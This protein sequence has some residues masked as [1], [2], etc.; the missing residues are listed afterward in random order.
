[1]KPMTGDQY[2]GGYTG[3]LLDVDLGR[4]KAEAMPWPGEWAETY[5]GGKGFGA[6]ILYDQLPKNCD[7]LS[8]QNILLFLAGPLTGTLAPAT[9]RT[10]LCTKSPATGL[11]LDANCGGFLGPELKMA[12]F[13]G[14]ILRGRARQ[15]VVVVID[16]EDVRFR[17]SPDLWGLDTFSTH[18]WVKENLG[19]DFR[20]AAIGEA[21]EK[22]V[23]FAGVISEYRAFG[24]GGAGAVMGSKNLKAVAVRGSQAVPIARPERFMRGVREAFNELA[25]HPD[26][27]GGRQKYGTNVILSTM[28]RTGIHPVKNFQK[29]SFQGA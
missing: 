11:W 24:R 26:T 21:G 12:G 1:M 6:R 18:R 23:L 7:P 19:G 16:D 25:I 22:G 3:K 8:P 9:G 5:L 14:L 4:E 29:G 17:P 13:D 20:V 2:R 15:P 28:N 10:V 27:G